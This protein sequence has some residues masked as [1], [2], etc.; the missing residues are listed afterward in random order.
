MQHILSHPLSEPLHTSSHRSPQPF[1]ALVVPPGH[2]KPLHPPPYP[3]NIALRLT[4]RVQM[5]AALCQVGV[6]SRC[7][8][9]RL[10]TRGIP[11]LKH[12]L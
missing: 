4:H 1:N 9:K 2:Q 12:L 8:C 10:C 7:M 11:L 6:V 3:Q 5:G